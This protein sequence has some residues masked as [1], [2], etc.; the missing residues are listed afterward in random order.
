MDQ[1]ARAM[2]EYLVQKNEYSDEVV[3]NMNEWFSTTEDVTTVKMVNKL[4]D[5]KLG[6]AG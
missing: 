6:R 3:T 5:V 4:V 2:F 1:I